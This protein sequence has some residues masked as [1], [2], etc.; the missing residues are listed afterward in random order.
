NGR[1]LAEALGLGG[2][3]RR[4]GRDGDDEPPHDH[5]GAGT[6][7]GPARDRSLRALQLAR[8]SRDARAAAETKSDQFERL[9]L[10]Y[11]RAA[12]FARASRLGAEPAA[13]SKDVAP[14]VLRP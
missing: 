1:R 12:F 13:A 10:R 8:P 2:L 7:R 5:S 6:P 14:S 11:R 4:D 3:R 9:I